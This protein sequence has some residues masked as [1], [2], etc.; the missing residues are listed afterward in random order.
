MIRFFILFSCL[1]PVEVLAE[2]IVLFDSG[3]TVPALPYKQIIL[4]VE[5]PDFGALWAIDKSASETVASDPSN[6]ANWLPITSTRLTP[7]KVAARV[8]EYNNLPSPVCVIGSGERSIKWL[9]KNHK[10]LAENNVLCW[11]V[12]APDLESVRNV[13]LA[14][15]GVSMA[16]ADG[17]A[18]ADFFSLRHYPVLITPRF[19]E[20]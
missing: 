5:I 6:P 7:G 12:E 9:Q 20:Q 19:I 11:L 18:I 16:P 15:D 14:L 10:A 8:V 1:L 2:P 17:D 3:R 13:I 4:D